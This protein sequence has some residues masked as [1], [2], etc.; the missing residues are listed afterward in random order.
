MAQGSPAD[1]E[2][3]IRTSVKAIGMGTLVLRR[4]FEK[5][6]QVSQEFEMPFFGWMPE[7]ALSGSGLIRHNATLAILTSCLRRHLVRNA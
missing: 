7:S 1:P 4:I 2:R 3:L 5:Y 6:L